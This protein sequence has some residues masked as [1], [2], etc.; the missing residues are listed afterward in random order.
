MRI[1]IECRTCGCLFMV[2]TAD[3]SVEPW[4]HYT[5]PECGRWFPAF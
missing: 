5:C 3:V 4:P 2:G 1:E